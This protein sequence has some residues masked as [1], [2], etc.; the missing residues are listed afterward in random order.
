[1][2]KDLELGDD[3]DSRFLVKRVQRASDLKSKTEKLIN[4]PI[5]NF[6]TTK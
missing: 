6:L 3:P 1:M 2:L 5:V 4:N